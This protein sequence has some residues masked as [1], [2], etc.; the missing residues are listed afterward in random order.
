MPNADCVENAQY[1]VIATMHTTAQKI[2]CSLR[3][4]IT[5]TSIFTFV[6]PPLFA[7][8]IVQIA[9]NLMN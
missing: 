9:L 4:R 5:S 6:A 8:I 2:F 1:A 7:Y 3:S